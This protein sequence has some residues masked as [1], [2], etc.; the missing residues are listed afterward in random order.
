MSPYAPASVTST[1][2]GTDVSP[3]DRGPLL[4]PHGRAE[5]FD[6]CGTILS[7]RLH[8]H[9][10]RT[11]RRQA[12]FDERRECRVEIRPAR[13]AAGPVEIDAHREL[14]LHDFQRQCPRLR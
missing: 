9:R 1:V 5:D 14:R 3:S 8:D 6:G 12:A 13:E 10:P 4:D 7:D 11:P 2:R